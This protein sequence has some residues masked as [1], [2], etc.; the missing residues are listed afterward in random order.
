MIALQ[1]AYDPAAFGVEEGQISKSIMPFLNEQ[2]MA[3]GQFLNLYSLKPSTDKQTRA[4]SIQ[5]RMRAGAVKF[6]KNTDWYQTLEDE[7]LRFPRDK[8][9]DQVDALAYLGQMIDK[10]VEAPTQQEK[11]DIEY[12]DEYARSGHLAAGRSLT[13][14]Y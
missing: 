13:T 12:A 3:T 8:H 14:G 10:M 5:A 1:K 6:D 7:C 4:R 9:D 11:H 2:M